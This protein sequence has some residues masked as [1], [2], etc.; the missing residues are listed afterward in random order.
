MLAGHS[1]LGLA[2]A[3]LIYLVCFSGVPAVFVAELEQWEQPR[4]PT[5]TYASDAAVTRAA[6]EGLARARALGADH[7]LQLFLPT[8]DVARL[9]VRAVGDDGTDHAWYADENGALTEGVSTPFSDFVAHFHADLHLPEPWGAYLV[10]LT[11]VALLSSLISGVLSHPRVFRDAFHLRWGGAKRLQEADLHNR[12]SI[13]GLPFHIAVSLTGAF[14]G[15]AGLI[16]TVLAFAAYDGDA[17]KAVEAVLGPQPGPSEAPAP[18]PDIAAIRARVLA[19]SPGAEGLFVIIEHPG[20]EGQVMT[21]DAIAPGH[22][23][24]AERYHFE[25]DGTFIRTAGGADGPMGMQIFAAMSPL[26]FGT[27]GGLAVKIAYGLLGLGLCVV[28]SSGVAIWLARRRDKGRPAPRWERIWIATVWSQPL[29]YGAVALAVVGFGL[30]PVAA[31]WTATAIAVV[32]GATRRDAGDTSRQLRLTGGIALAIGGLVPL[33]TQAAFT[34]I[35]VAVGVTILAF[36]CALGVSSLGKAGSP[37][38]RET[39]NV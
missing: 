20:T 7:S 19:M 14:L 25:G 16:V 11:G 8:E 13:W 17:G 28:T 12:I 26:H 6:E 36:A 30:S 31:W 21:Y 38:S 27:F 23:A 18:L 3:A 32:W 2:F 15:L 24:A 22:L 34:P 33:L 9:R 35:P 29:A 5:V 39:A 1:G 10:G 4:Q 37:P